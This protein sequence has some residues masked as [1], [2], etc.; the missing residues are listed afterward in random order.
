MKSTLLAVVL[1]TAYSALGTPF[2]NLD[3]EEY[4]PGDTIFEGLTAEADPADGENRV[5]RRQL[6]EN[7]SN[8]FHRLAFD[9]PMRGERLAFE[10]KVRM[11]GGGRRELYVELNQ[12]A[13]PWRLF[14]I[15]QGQFRHGGNPIL[16]MEND[17]WY[18]VVGFMETDS[19]TL[20]LNLFELETGRLLREADFPLPN[21]CNETPIDYAGGFSGTTIRYRGHGG[22]IYTDDIRACAV[23]EGAET[24]LAA[25]QRRV[26]QTAYRRAQAEHL[27]ES[28]RILREAGLDDR[29]APVPQLLALLADEAAPASL[30]LRAVA[31]LA[32]VG[33]DSEAAVNRLRD[34]LLGDETLWRWAAA[35]ALDI[36]LETM[37]EENT[38]ATDDFNRVLAA[39]DRH[40]PQAT[41]NGHIY[42]VWADASRRPQVAKICETTGTAAI[43]PLDP[44]PDYLA[45]EDP[46][47]RFSLGIDADGHI[48]VTGDM[49]NHPHHQPGG[50]PER[51]RGSHILYW[52]SERPE[53]AS[54]FVFQGHDPE[55]RVPGY[56]FTYHHFNRDNHGILYLMSRVGGYHTRA[57]GLF[58][59]DVRTR[60]WTARG[61]LDEP[62]LTHRSNWQTDQPIFLFRVPYGMGEHAYYQGYMCNLRFGYDNRMHIAIAC[63]A[64]DDPAARNT[65]L[66]YAYSDDGGESFHRIDGSRIE[67][68]PMRIDPPANRPSIVVANQNIGFTPASPFYDRD[69]N[70][71]VSVGNY[72]YYGRERGEWAGPVPSPVHRGG[73]SVSSYLDRDGIVTFLHGSNLYRSPGLKPD[74]PGLRYLVQGSMASLDDA[75]LRER[76]IF[77]AVFRAGGTMG[78]KTVR[79]S[80]RSLD[81]LRTEFDS[82]VTAV[83][84]RAGAAAQNP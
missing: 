33:L 16:P 31:N 74:L 44:D 27:E 41:F 55:R 46:H 19:R 38:F 78:I 37:H 24:F 59:Y 64:V 25:K 80:P 84:N 12:N 77:R 39:D 67:Q 83:A 13:G 35:A 58:Q 75:L 72:W 1:A 69:G 50:L 21:A 70:V 65:H 4:G 52:V 81:E 22:T 53:D 2:L 47:N 63:N 15:W 6:P 30:R 45:L 49:H 79:F 29:E 36:P 8:V 54:S 42:F 73:W 9:P 23:A 76:G 20:R 17:I 57:V 43:F 60:K 14:E 71:A 10:I 62:M 32:R 11:A 56:G 18:Q 40:G 26:A 7:D 68:L 82:R 51:Y 48:H 28:R 3:F 34:L 5:A 61:A 66:V